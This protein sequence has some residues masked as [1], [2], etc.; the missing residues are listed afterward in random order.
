MEA[1]LDTRELDDEE[2][3]RISSALERVDLARVGEG[4][5]AMPGEADTFQYD[6]EVRRGDESHAVSFSQ[7]QMPDEL[8][9]V[10]RALM[11][12]AQ[13]GR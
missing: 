2:A 6:L 11:D 5:A 9:P 12:R 10:V 4:P 8:A 1:A 7:R 13:P 3:G